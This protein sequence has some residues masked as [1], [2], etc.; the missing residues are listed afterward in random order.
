MPDDAFAFLDGDLRPLTEA[1]IPITDRG[2]LLG[3]GV[4]ETLRAYQGTPFRWDL[5]RNRLANGLRALGLRTTA[6]KMADE[7]VETLSDAATTDH[8]Y[9]RLQVTR[10]PTVRDP[11][12]ADGVVTGIVRPLVPYPDRTYTEGI[13]VAPVSWRKDPDDALA[14]VKHVS[15]LPYLM[16]RRQARAA[17]ADDA[18]IRNTDDRFCEAS[19]SNLLAVRGSAVFSPGTDEG[20]LDGVTRRLLLETIESN[21]RNVVEALT[22]T[23]LSSADEF[24]LLNTVGGVVPVR[25]VNGI[26]TRLAGARGGV[27][28]TLRSAYED[29]I[30]E[31]YA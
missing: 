19:H 22:E 24:V 18:L 11:E 26:P 27:F 2:F 23:Q 28:A 15:Y 12:D 25:E 21:G 3:D 16:A 4:F 9:L 29:L 1:R 6:L 13:A 14:R 10:D 7:A 5:H 17:G 30:T 20:A 31:G 8:A